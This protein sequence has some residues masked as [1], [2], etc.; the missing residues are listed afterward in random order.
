MNN[1]FKSIF[2]RLPMSWFCP[3]P[4]LALTLVVGL[5]A[6]SSGSDTG[7]GDE[8]VLNLDMAIPNSLTGG[9]AGA[10]LLVSPTGA[11]VTAANTDLPC[12]YQGPDDDDDPF[13]NGYEM[14]K[15]MVFLGCFLVGSS[16]VDLQACKLEY[17]IVSPK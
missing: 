5:S 14:T 9:P 7:A 4:A 6:C 3:L 16:R 10:T 1:K 15:F 2:Y 11:Q 8:E 17:S 12:A 13:R